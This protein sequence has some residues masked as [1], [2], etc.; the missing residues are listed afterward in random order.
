[1]TKSR[2]IGRT[3]E[4]TAIFVCPEDSDDKATVLKITKDSSGKE[5]V[6]HFSPD[7]ANIAEGLKIAE[8]FFGPDD[9]RLP[10]DIQ[11][12]PTGSREDYVD[13]FNYNSMWYQKDADENYDENKTNA[14]NRVRFA[15]EKALDA[16]TKTDAQDS[17]SQNLE[18]LTENGETYHRIKETA[19]G[20]FAPRSDLTESGDSDDGFSITMIEQGWS[21]NNRYYTTEAIDDFVTLAKERDVVSF[22]NHGETFNRD[23]RDWGAMVSDPVREGVKAKATLNVFDEPDGPFLRERINK[24]P[25]LF[26]VSVD[27]FA[28]IESGEAEGRKGTMVTEILRYNS[29]DVVMFPGAKGGFD[30]TQESVNFESE[31][32]KGDA[33]PMNL[34]ELKEKHPDAVQLVITEVTAEIEAGHNE[35]IAKLEADTVTSDEK[36]KEAEK[37]LAE[38]QAKV[39]EFET[40]QAQGEFKEKLAT[41]LAAELSETALTEGYTAICEK[42]GADQWE[43][44]ESMTQERK[45]SFKSSTFISE[46][47]RTLE[48]ENDYYTEDKVDPVAKAEAVWTQ[49]KTG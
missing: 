18:S 49:A 40:K 47:D 26:G 4:G 37:S 2:I 6:Q 33:E 28:K 36:L 30:T 24:A 7:D 48:T 22:F 16:V 15:M 5:V 27:A 20:V 38:A 29:L 31:D 9:P 1:M 19:F 3:S 42:L 14:V 45:E 41:Y 43:T 25:G 32:H 39:D 21:L 23:P 11:K 13:E 35:Q 12:M 34:K 8:N 10:E 44:I 46:G 17:E